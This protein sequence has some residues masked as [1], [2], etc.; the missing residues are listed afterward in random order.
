MAPASLNRHLQEPRSTGR[1]KSNL[2]V[3]FGAWDSHMHVSDPSAYPVA[4]AAKYEPQKHTLD[5][6]LQFETA[7]GF[8]NI[9]LVQPSTFGTDNSNLLDALRDLQ[10]NDQLNGRGIVVVDPNQIDIP[11]LQEWHHL[12]V[13]GVRLNFTSNGLDADAESGLLKDIERHAHWVTQMNW[14]I[15][16]YAPLSSLSKLAATLPSQPFK[17][18]FDHFGNPTDLPTT[19]ENNSTAPFDPYELRGFRE[20]I[21]LLSSPT[22]NVYVKLSAP[23][24]LRKNRNDVIGKLAAS[25]DTVIESITRELLRKAPSR[26]VFATD[27]PHTRFEGLDISPFVEKCARWCQEI[28]GEELLDMVFRRNAMELW[29]SDG[30]E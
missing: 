17:F 8:R 2:M 24:R 7:L 19:D 9:V 4:P 3:P 25:C 15:Q 23:Y 29:D 13:R 6:A 5:E 28:G 30:G 12:G 26:L 16:I 27:W 10:S 22:A 1:E 21:N 20:L 14:V 11:T 18:C